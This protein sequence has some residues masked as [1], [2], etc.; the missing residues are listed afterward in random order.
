MTKIKFVILCVFSGVLF[1]HTYAQVTPTTEVYH[2]SISLSNLS[3][4][5]EWYNDWDFFGSVYPNCN[6]NCSL[7]DPYLT[8]SIYSDFITTDADHNILLYYAEG[9]PWPDGQGAMFEQGVNYADPEE[10][11]GVIGE[12]Y[13]H[14]WNS[15]D[16]K[17]SAIAAKN[18][19]VNHDWGV[20]NENKTFYDLMGSEIP[21]KIEITAPFECLKTLRIQGLSTIYD[22]GVL[23]EG[24]KFAPEY[25]FRE[26]PD[27]EWSAPIW[28]DLKNPK[29]TFDIKYAAHRGFW[30]T[31]LGAGPAEN[32]PPAIVA[33]ANYTKIMESDITITADDS[34]VVSHDYNL[35]RLTNY[36]NPNFQNKFIYNTDFHAIEGLYLRKKDGSITNYKFLQLRDLIAFVKEQESVLTIDLKE[37]TKRLNP[38]TND[39]T[40]ACQLDNDKTIQVR[41]WVH[42][43]SRILDIVEQEDAWGYVAV[44]TP[45][46]INTIKQ[47]LAE[48]RYADMRK[49][50]YFPVIQANRNKNQSL[51]FINDWYNNGSNY[52]IGFET[53][54]KTKD[55][56]MHSFTVGGDSY[57][58]ILNYVVSRTYLRPGLYSEEPA[59]PKG[60]VDRYAQ[61]KIKNLNEDFRGDPI[62]LLS[63]PYFSTAIVTT[64][65]IDIWNQLELIYGFT[66]TQSVSTNNFN[67]STTTEIEELDLES[68][69]IYAQH[70]L[71]KIV[72]SGLNP[73]DIGSNI[74]LYDLQGR[75]IYHNILDSEPKVILSQNLRAGIYLL[76]I[77]GSRQKS[78]KLI[79]K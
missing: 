77:S 27:S 47:Y 79:V 43:F 53:N 54:F 71:G 3:D 18:Y 38:I 59:G 63:F 21:I 35:Q 73:N 75:L 31:N 16:I 66:S 58:N 55:E 61:W 60:V 41:A 62:W 29:T 39:C 76:R 20:K 13:P 28:H 10:S 74:Q 52:L 4:L 42:L 68:V 36:D 5:D 40:A 32:T 17:S 14:P 15:L 50:L 72:V 2:S 26:H 11:L 37:I 69:P 44:K 45:H 65:R 7:V 67:A 48:D 34:V 30:G 57:E 25:G 19:Y 78:I 6:C 49:M 23:N 70:E 8:I 64:D 46:T 33:A 22:D 12:D 1:T 56:R 24:L 9:Y 51:D